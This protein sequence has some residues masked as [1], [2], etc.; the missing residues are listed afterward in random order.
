MSTP[1]LT[2]N[3][4]ER[5]AS[6]QRENPQINDLILYLEQGT[7]PDDSK[8]AKVIVA[9]ARVVLPVSVS[10]HELELLQQEGPSRKPCT[11]SLYISQPLQRFVVG[12]HNSL[13]PIQIG[14]K[15]SR[16]PHRRATLFKLRS[17]FSR[18]EKE[19]GWRTVSLSLFL[20]RQFVTTQLQLQLLMK[21]KKGLVQF[22]IIS[23]G[24]LVSAS[25]NRST[26]LIGR[27]PNDWVL[28]SSATSSSALQCRRIP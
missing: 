6:E 3:I 2:I 28:P 18:Q 13:S 14:P 17:T 15:L 19:Y 20:H 8:K 7:L 21:K 22:G 24:S 12:L 11:S 4:I 26:L 23:T 25:R 9:E 16:T 1:I 5:V 10:H 27:D